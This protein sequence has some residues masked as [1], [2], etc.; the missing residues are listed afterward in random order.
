MARF[1]LTTIHADAT[2]IR[3]KTHRDVPEDWAAT[4][5]ALELGRIHNDVPLGTLVDLVERQGSR[6]ARQM[7]FVDEDRTFVVTEI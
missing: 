7:A 6:M 1:R 4:L 5:I 2:T 3:H